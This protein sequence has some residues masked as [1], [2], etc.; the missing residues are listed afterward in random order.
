MLLSIAEADASL[1]ISPAHFDE[2]LNGKAVP[3]VKLGRR[4]MVRVDDL[5]AFVASLETA[6]IATLFGMA[7]STK[8]PRTSPT[9]VRSPLHGE[10][11][12][13]TVRC[14]VED[15]RPLCSALGRRAS[16]A[17]FA[18]SCSTRAGHP[19]PGRGELRKTGSPY[20]FQRVGDGDLD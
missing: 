9:A 15:T 1:R 3:T 2:F 5:A 16:I 6:R 10:S 14:D 8:S 7:T 4:R 12:S 11:T 17:V 19:D 20:A 13:S 18:L